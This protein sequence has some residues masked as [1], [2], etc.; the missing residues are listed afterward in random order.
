MLYSYVV[1]VRRIDVKVGEKKLD[2][3]TCKTFHVQES[4]GS[5][6]NKHSTKKFL[7]KE[8]ILDV[9]WWFCYVKYRIFSN[10]DCECE[11]PKR[12][13]KK[14]LIKWRSIQIYV[15]LMKSSQRVRCYI[16][17]FCWNVFQSELIPNKVL[18]GFILFNLQVGCYFIVSRTYFKKN[19]LKEAGVLPNHR[20]YD[21]VSSSNY[22]RI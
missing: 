11:K 21:M 6:I 19:I 20:G 1:E 15:Q 16:R 9:R 4:I 18:L 2:N 13:K 17:F 14:P 8:D 12:A 10:S 3:S 7:C 5:K 22:H